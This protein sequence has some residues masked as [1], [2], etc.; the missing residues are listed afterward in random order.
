MSEKS[1]PQKQ[2]FNT[3]VERGMRKKM[4][5][6]MWSCWCGKF[7]LFVSSFQLSSK[8]IFSCIKH[9]LETNQQGGYERN[10]TLPRIYFI[11]RE[12]YFIRRTLENFSFLL[13]QWIIKSFSYSIKTSTKASSKIVEE[14]NWRGWCERVK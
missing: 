9:V 4:F 3:D 12:V 10:N 7:F 13:S 14:K 8:D 2:F 6:M 11:W 1:F 5:L